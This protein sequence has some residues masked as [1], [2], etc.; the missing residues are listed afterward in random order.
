MIKIVAACV[1]GA[2]LAGGLALVGTT[3]ATQSSSSTE[4]VNQSLYNYGDR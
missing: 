4:P 1:I 3:F 2:A